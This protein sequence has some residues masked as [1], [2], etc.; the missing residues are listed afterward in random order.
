MWVDL[1][2]I[3]LL[4]PSIESHL[5]VFFGKAFILCLYLFISRLPIFVLKMMG[6]FGVVG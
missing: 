1:F 6:A 4:N 5:W 3:L 2:L